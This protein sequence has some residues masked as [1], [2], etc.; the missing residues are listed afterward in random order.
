MLY[1]QHVIYH[2]CTASIKV[3]I[4]LHILTFAIVELVVVSCLDM[5]NQGQ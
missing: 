5:D 4:M 3:I 2:N 1:V